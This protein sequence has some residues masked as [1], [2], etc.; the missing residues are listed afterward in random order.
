MEWV[1]CGHGGQIKWRA[2]SSFVLSAQGSLEVR[3]VGQEP[4][5]GAPNPVAAEHLSSVDTG[6]PALPTKVSITAMI[7][8][9]PSC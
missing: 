1:V 3:V 8:R 5:E 9:W 6:F 2:A 4:V 7:G